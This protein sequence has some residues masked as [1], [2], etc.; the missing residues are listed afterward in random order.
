LIYFFK[1][2]YLSRDEED[3]E[4]TSFYLYLIWSKKKI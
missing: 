2:I 3:E 4:F 1:F